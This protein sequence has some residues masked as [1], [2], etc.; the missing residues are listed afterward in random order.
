MPNKPTDPARKVLVREAELKR[1]QIK[2]VNNHIVALEDSLLRARQEI[3]N[4]TDAL[5]SVNK[6]IELL[7]AQP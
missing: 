1:E 6:T 3:I 5:D 4:L 2:S 7:D